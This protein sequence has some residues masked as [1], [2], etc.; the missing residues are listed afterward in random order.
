MSR[1]SKVKLA[2]KISCVAA[3]LLS[4]VL[5]T[6]SVIAWE[7]SDVVSKA[8]NADTY[9]TVNG[10]VDPN[11]DTEYFK[12]EYKKVGD[13]IKAGRD[14]TVKVV[15]EGSVLLKNDN[16]ALPLAKNSKVT[17]IGAG[18]F[19][20]VYGGTGS[21]G[22][23]SAE[24]VDFEQSLTD[25]GFSVNPTVADAY[26]SDAWKQYKRSTSGRYGT[27]R[28][29]IG[30][31]P[32]SEFG[33]LQAS[34]DEYGDA[35][36]MVISRIGGEGYDLRNNPMI[37][38]N[39][40]DG[41]DNNDGLGLDYLG[42]NANEISI[43]QGLKAMKDEGKIKKIVVLIN[44]ASMLEG[45]FIKD[46][47]YG[48][49]A[50]MWI[51][52][53]ALGGAAVGRL[54]A[55]DVSPSGRL[56]DTMFL[57]NA[58]NPVNVNFAP[59]KYENSEE[60]GLSAVLGSS[61]Y[62]EYSLAAYSVYQEGVYLGYK[63]TETRYED[64]VLNTSNVGNY[65]YNDVVAYPFAYG[66]SYADF[67]TSDVS[68]EKTG[69][70]EYTVSV[71]VTNTSEDNVSGK[72]SVP[73]YVSKP[74][75][76][77]AKTNGI[78]VP[79]V[80]LI[81][82]AKTKTLA[83]GES[84][85]LTVKLDEKF[86]A[87]Y[88]AEN[89]KTYVLMDGDYYVCV[90]GSAHEATNN[91]LMAKKANGISVNESKMVGSG[92]ASKVVKFRLS[93]DKE[94]YAYSD[95]VSAL[96]GKAGTKITNLFDFAD[97]NRYEG[98]GDNHVDYYDRSDWA[99]TVSLDMVNGY[100]KVRATE[101][102]AK[103]IYAQVP[104]GTGK[105]NNAPPV[106]DKYKQPIPK[107]DVAY[108]TM[109]ADNG[110]SLLDLRVDSEGNPISYFDPIWDDLLD[111]LTWEELSLLPEIGNRSTEAIA[112][113][114]KPGTSQTNGPNGF[115]TSY[116]SKTG[117]GY[118]MEV[119]AGH[120]DENGDLI[121]EEADPDLYKKSTG[122]PSN[123]TLAA[124]FNKELAAQVGSII[125]EDG[126]WAG[127]QGIYGLGLN[128]HRSS[129]LGRT[130]EYYSEDGML[131]GLI[132]A[133]ESAAIEAK[134]V[135]V[136]NKH[137]ALND[138]EYNRHG[139]ACWIPE[140][141]LREIY[142]RA[143]ELPITMGNSTGTMQSFSRFGPYSGAACRALGT[144]FLRGECGMIGIIVTDYY[145]DMDGSQNFDPYFEQAYGNYVGGCDLCDGNVTGHFDKFETGY[146]EMAWA[147]R[148]T[149]K[150]ILYHT[151]TSCA[152]NGLSASTQ[153]IRITPWWQTLL[154]SLDVVIGAI[155]VGLLTWTVVDCAITY[156]KER[157]RT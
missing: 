106:P 135:H 1:S 80:E 16:D 99:G 46:P 124:T 72:Y 98:R 118:R 145:G 4:G 144:D 111:Q 138:M 95:A 146:G 21:G 112:S 34:I 60:V 81:E 27:T 50:A 28:V 108:P 114:N 91:L 52:A 143:F 71:K 136:Y 87:S 53:P 104:E 133:A 119:A 45:N 2:R 93:Y 115:N 125:G 42:L 156:K 94:K 15:E 89:A 24:A 9:I 76:Q 18:A 113:V 109:G 17:L 33:D 154:I 7:N 35:A 84:Q 151:V 123:G 66:L 130:C 120:V 127:K 59:R 150:R 141:A 12:S 8:L 105:Y 74:Y 51:G 77:Y 61:A 134:G 82:F 26:K 116:T 70:R 152:I 149:A 32:W 139:V 10:E 5:I 40:H 96:T 153:V 73:I 85:V 64:V 38:F 22:I 83:K 37:G 132:G 107:D 147:L 6:G 62:T 79:S 41:I 88:D 36:V 19:N 86:F 39:G 117:L 155:F 129:Y 11:E 128:I 49:D 13:L 14:T 43:L 56:S 25:A 148:E 58:M 75:G 137:C 65:N 157:N 78:Q 142:L 126:I 20:P 54:L 29:L 140:Q 122:F 30:E 57:D 101:Q 3:M 102:L 23:S 68:V 55:G 44:Y 131:T 100:A 90:G 121:R 69:T 48:I 67:E 47:Q 63:Y 31:A 97:I 92:D 103:E 110:L